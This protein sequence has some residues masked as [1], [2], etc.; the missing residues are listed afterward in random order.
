MIVVGLTGSIATGK[1]FV[2]N[3]FK[4]IGYPVFN[5]DDC[6]HK[7]ITCNSK[8]IDEISVLF[9]NVI[10]QGEIDK[11]T[12]SAEVFN[13]DKSLKKLENIL[14]GKVRESQEEFLHKSEKEGFKLAILEIPLLFESKSKIN[15]D[16]IIV[17][18]VDENIQKQRV[19]AR[20]GMTEQLFY[21]ILS[22][23]MPSSEKITLADL[24]INTNQSKKDV[25]TAI[26]DFVARII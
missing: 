2:A 26:D 12:L 17:T 22:K 20:Q 4:Q 21:K 14:H 18:H 7:L 1:T 23:Q 15:F 8:V 5:S 9:P 10:L 24:V 6:V 11:K 3:Y 16:Y 13:D 25:C 19:L